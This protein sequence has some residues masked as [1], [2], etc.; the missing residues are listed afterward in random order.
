[1]G[2]WIDGCIERQIIFKGFVSKMHMLVLYSKRIND[3]TKKK[4]IGERVEQTIH[5]KR[6]RNSQ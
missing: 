2:R 1:M 5:K 4:K 6:Y 3:S